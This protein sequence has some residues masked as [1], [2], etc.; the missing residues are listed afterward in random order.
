MPSLGSL[1]FLTSLLLAVFVLLA[2]PAAAEKLKV[3]ASFSI[4]GDLVSKVGGA[5][6]ELKTLVGPNGDAH[7]YDPTPNDQRALAE[8]NLLIANGFGFEPWLERLK[9]A[10]GFKGATVIAT[11]GVP[12]LTMQE[13]GESQPVTDP[14]AF[15]SLANAEIYVAN[16]LKG[17]IA[18]DPAHAADYRANAQQ[19]SGDIQAL[20][21]EIIGEIAAIPPENR[22]ILTSHDAFQYFS[23]AYGIEF[24]SIQGVSTE[25]EPSAADLA[26][27][28]DQVKREKVKAIFLENMSNPALA[29]TIAAETGVAVGGELYADALSEPDGPAADYLRLFRH[30]VATILGVLR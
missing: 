5:N 2:G 15:Q 13:E 8:A 28:S 1:R 21:R 30:N 11:D 3:V 7:T 18:A 4:L 17:L 23:K 22:R 20:D 14:H 12:P 29:K 10:A 6:I 24:L 27:L 19:F 16:I 9:G 26:K 25:A